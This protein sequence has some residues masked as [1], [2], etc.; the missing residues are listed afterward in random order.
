[1]A[2]DVLVHSDHGDAVKPG[3]VIYQ[4]PSALGQD[5]VIGGVPGH[6]QSLGQP[7]DSQVL[8]HQGN[9]RPAHRCP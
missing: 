5:R 2:P 1:M 8:G 6:S 4:D 9:Q 3:G 7:G